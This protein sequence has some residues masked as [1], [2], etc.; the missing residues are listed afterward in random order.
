MKTFSICDF[1]VNNKEPYWR[2][3]EIY[4]KITD[5]KI[6]AVS[7]KFFEDCPAWSFRGAGI[8][9]VSIEQVWKAV[10]EFDRLK[11]MADIFS[12]V[13]YDKSQKKLKLKIKLLAIE[14]ELVL[15]FITEEHLKEDK[16][17]KFVVEYG[18]L[19]TLEGEL[20]LKIYNSQETEVGLFAKYPD[21]IERWPDWIF[22]FATEA[23]MSRV[24]GE[25]RKMVEL[26][27]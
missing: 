1:E 24:A 12:E 8:V 23:V 11:K 6:I 20:R 10:F 26:G 7:S 22:A 2:K 21:K 15:R 27:L 4:K 19:K 13:D 18:F 9:R 3:P 17:L 16:K 25:L 5:D 14:K